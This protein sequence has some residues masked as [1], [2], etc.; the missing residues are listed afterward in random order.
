MGL[1]DKIFGGSKKNDDNIGASY[2]Q[3]LSGTTPYFTKFNDN[4][5]EYDTVRATI[6]TIASAAAKLNAKHIRKS[7]KQ[8]ETIAG[9]NGYTQILGE[10]PNPFM[11]AYDFQYKIITNLLLQSNA[12]IYPVYENGKISGFYPINYTNLELLEYKNVIYCRFSFMNGKRLTVEYTDIIHLRRYYNE[13]DFFGDSNST[14]LNTT[15]KLLK[16]SDEGIINAIKTSASLRGILTAAGMLNDKDMKKQKENFERDYLNISNSGGIAVLDSKFNYKPIES[17]PK[18]MD[19]NQMKAIDEKVYRFFNVNE[20]IVK[21]QYNEDE[22]NAFYESVI[23]PLALQLSMEFT[24]C[25]FSQNEQAFG[26]MIMYDSNR[27]QY[28]SSKTKIALVKELFDRGMLSRNE[29]RE[30]FNMSPVE[31]GDDYFISLNFAKSQDIEE[32]QLGKLGGK[33]EDD[34]NEG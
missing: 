10:R 8:V 18:L 26:N 28:A 13:N 32:Y 31:D 1:F 30:I 4:A 5:Y 22:W 6:H 2:Y 17:S 25:L 3:M 29:G 23:E 16:T 15:L 33:G 12:F 9:R 27:L 7:G 34:N 24:N 14:A 21:S 11:S 20:N 19:A